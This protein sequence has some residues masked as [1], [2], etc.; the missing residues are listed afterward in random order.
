M[1]ENKK[2][3]GFAGFDS[4]VSNIEVPKSK[5]V[6]VPDAVQQQETPSQ[7]RTTPQTVYAG[8]QTTDGGSGKWWA[9][10]VGLV[11]MISWLMGT[12]N[13]SASRPAAAIPSYSAPSYSAPA[14]AAA[15]AYAPPP[16]Y[17]SDTSEERPPV[18]SGL[19]LNR[20]QIRYC[21][22]QKIRISSWQ[23]HVDN[24]SKSSVDVFN[25]AV[26]NYNARCSNFRY[27]SGLLESVRSEVEANR[28]ALQIEGSD[29][30][31]ANP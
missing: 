21:L 24:Y 16:S 23:K 7:A 11:V 30:A 17:E 28:Y 8:K 31:A 14:P 5:P 29:S 20:A 25:G 22:S 9:I 12:D 18:G 13:K 15:P 3:K 2:R 4:M 1:G 6:P 19:I 27:R 10:G 26:A